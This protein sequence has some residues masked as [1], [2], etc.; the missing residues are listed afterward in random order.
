MKN[1]KKFVGAAAIAG[2]L[3]GIGFGPAQNASAGPFG[4]G[5]PTP[6][7]PGTASVCVFTVQDPDDRIDRFY[8]TNG[9]VRVLSPQPAA[10]TRDRVIP[11]FTLFPGQTE[12]CVE[13]DGFKTCAPITV[14]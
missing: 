3:V 5:C 11:I 9:S 13:G 12:I 4:M 10:G 1:W 14:Q 8:S 6:L 7:A 2:A